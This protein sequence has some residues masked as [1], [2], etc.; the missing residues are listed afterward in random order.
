LNTQANAQI[1]QAIADAATRTQAISAV[2]GIYDDI[3]R[4]ISQI[5]PICQLSGKCCRFEEYGHRLYVTTAELAT[6]VAMAR[7]TPAPPHLLD[8]AD[9]GG[10]RFQQNRLCTVHQSR[11]MGCRMFYCD[12]RTEQPL[13]ELFE[14][15]H[16]RLKRIHDDLQIPYYYLEWRAALAIIAPL[17]SPPAT[18][19]DDCPKA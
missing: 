17:L 5:G 1:A 15:M 13:Q 12:P 7:Q 14:Q 16:T 2:S 11:P 18:H 4:Q 9:G 8:H 3:A 10:C 19:P 6:F